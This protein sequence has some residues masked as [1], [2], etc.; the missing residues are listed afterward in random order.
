MVN[1]S[2][3]L[4]IS[5]AYEATY[6]SKKSSQLFKIGVAMF[7]GGGKCYWGRDCRLVRVCYLVRIYNIYL[8]L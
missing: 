4:L 5:F 3:S 8:R 7:S 6:S 1:L 2:Q